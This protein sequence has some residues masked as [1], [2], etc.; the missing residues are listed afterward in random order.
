MK[1]KLL[2]IILALSM[3]A[4]LLAG[5]SGSSADT[6]DTDAVEET[7]EAAA[8]TTDEAADAAEAVDAPAYE[9]GVSDETADPDALVD[10]SVD[11]SGLKVGVL[12]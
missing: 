4:L 2:S 7:T 8:E 10:P 11:Y 5:C 1:K 12:L 3:A 6:A 9:F